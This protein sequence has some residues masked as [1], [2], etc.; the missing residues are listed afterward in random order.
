MDLY[1][2]RQLVNV[3]IQAYQDA[4]LYSCF[5]EIPSSCGDMKDLLIDGFR[6]ALRR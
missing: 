3:I 5:V 6:S 1:P 4:I 2:G